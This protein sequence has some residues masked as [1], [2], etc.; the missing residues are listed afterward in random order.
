MAA[1]VLIAIIPVAGAIILFLS[2]VFQQTLLDQANGDLQQLQSAEDTFQTYQSNNALFNALAKASGDQ[3]D[4]ADYIRTVQIY[5]YELGLREMEGL[6]DDGD[7]R[8]IPRP[9]NAYDGSP[10]LAEKMDIVQDR[11]TRIQGG[12][13]SKKARIQEQKARYARIFFGTYALGSLMVLV[14]SVLTVLRGGQV[15]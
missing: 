12:I 7:R 2:W 9:V 15:G 13:A 1:K 6:L 4:T 14:G 11:L 3:Q 8:D 5:N 10:P